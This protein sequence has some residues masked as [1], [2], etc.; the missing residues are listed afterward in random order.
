MCLCSLNG[1]IYFTQIWKKKHISSY[2]WNKICDGNHRR[3]KLL[4]CFAHIWEIIQILP[5]SQ[6]KF[7]IRTKTE[8]N[9]EEENEE[10]NE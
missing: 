9:K 3:N 6:W 2:S 5:A 10:T 4:F 8:K 1:P 7:G